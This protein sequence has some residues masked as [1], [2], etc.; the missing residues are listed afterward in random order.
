MATHA[1]HTPGPKG[2]TGSTVAG[3]RD[4]AAQA[5]TSAVD[6]VKGAAG[7]AADKVRQVASTVGRQAEGAAAAVGETFQDSG[8]YLQ[9]RDLSGM[10]E[11]CTGLVRRY[12]LPAL[13][14]GLAAGYCMGR[15]LRS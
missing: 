8:R 11:D 2:D 4:K 14:L 3:A 6:A 13:L 5:A 9:E 15:I 7:T 12:P 1:S 10:L